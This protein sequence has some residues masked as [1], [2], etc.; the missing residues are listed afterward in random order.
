M[1]MS[2]RVAKKP[3]IRAQNL[4]KQYRINAGTPAAP[5]MTLRDTLAGAARSPLKTLRRRKERLNGEMV[6]ALKDM[7]FE[8]EPGEAVGVIGRNGAGKSTLLKV[9]SRITEPTTGRIELYG[10][11][12]SLLEVG[13]GFSMELS[14][15]EN[16]YL[17]G[18]ILGMSRA[19]IRHKFDEIVAFS[20][21]EKFIDTPVKYYSSGMY[22]RL[23]FAVAAHLEPDILIV[24]EVLA[25][26]DAAFQKKCLGKMSNAA[27]EGRA[28]L[29][30][31]HNFEAARAFCTRC[32]LVNQGM[33][34]EDNTPAVSIAKAFELQ[35]IANTHNTFEVQEI[36]SSNAVPKPVAVEVSASG[37][38]MGE[39]ISFNDD[40]VVSLE[41]DSPVRDGHTFAFQ[42]FTSTGVMIFNSFYRDNAANP[43]L[44]PGITQKICTTIPRS[45]LPGGTYEAAF[46]YMLPNAELFWSTRETWFEVQEVQSYRNEGLSVNREGLI[47]LVLP[48]RS[49]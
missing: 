18:A 4:G 33:I 41:L 13:T 20:E 7:N 43:P 10:R 26:G 45:L 6:W 44:K 11:V 24:D 2:S 21:V 12:A 30:V 3:I 1:L 9:L 29:F 28:V 23:A 8:V 42:V 16:V 5:Y 25:V 46:A 19:E 35:Q 47:S 32:L 49:S 38:E 36:R 48:W 27:A 22:L 17:N 39:P 15:R 14:G 31:T 34:V 40:I 37:K